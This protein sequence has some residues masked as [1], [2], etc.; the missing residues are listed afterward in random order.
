MHGGSKATWKI[1][2]PTQE[3]WVNP[4]IGWSAS[5]DVAESS[6]RKMTFFTAEEAAQFLEKQGMQYTIE[7]KPPNFE[8]TIRPPRFLQYGDNFSTKRAG[9][10]DLS[11]LPSNR[12]K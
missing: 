10:P 1:W 4:L 9:V 5:S 8:R 7:H 11:H 12:K 6:F 2:L 3:M